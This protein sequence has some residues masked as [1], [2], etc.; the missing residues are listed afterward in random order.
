MTEARRG[1]EPKVRTPFPHDCA[2]VALDLTGD[3]IMELAAPCGAPLSRARSGSVDH[4]GAEPKVRT[5]LPHDCA[6]VA[7]G[8]ELAAPCGARR[9]ARNETKMEASTWSSTIHEEVPAREQC[10]APAVQG[11][12]SRSKARLEFS[13]VAT[14]TPS[15]VQPTAMALAAEALAD[16]SATAEAA[17]G[18][19]QS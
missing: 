18:R 12:R 2:G 6:G 8:M 14:A 10:E 16:R 9:S 11:E 4:R 13:T 17:I 5:P 7:L 1:A 15:T 3:T 19:V